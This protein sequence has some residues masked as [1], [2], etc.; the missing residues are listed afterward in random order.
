M[1]LERLRH[2]RKGMPELGAHVGRRASFTFEELAALA[3]MSRM[4]DELGIG[5]ATLTPLSDEIFALFAD[6]DEVGE[7]DT[8]LCV[9]STGVRLVRLPATIHDPVIAMARTDLILTELMERI[10]SPGKRAQLPL[11]L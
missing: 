2:W 5:A 4:T 7:P 8:A 9:T 3:V 10:A 11:P 6:D 1:S